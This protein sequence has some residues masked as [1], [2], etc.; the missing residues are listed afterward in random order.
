MLVSVGREGAVFGE[1]EREVFLN[2]FQLTAHT[3]SLP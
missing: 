2:T 3:L 1:I